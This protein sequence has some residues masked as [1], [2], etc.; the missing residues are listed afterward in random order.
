MTRY[1]E[2]VVTTDAGLRNR[3]APRAQHPQLSLA[4]IFLLLARLRL[5]RLQRRGL[6]WRPASRATSRGEMP[7]ASKGAGVLL[8][9]L[10]L[11]FSFGVQ[12]LTSLMA[13]VRA[14]GSTSLLRHAPLLASL[15][16]AC[17]LTLAIG[18][19]RTN[20]RHEGDEAAWLATL[21]APAW[22]LQAAKLGEAAL[23]NLVGWLLLFP[24]FNSLAIL[25]GLG[26]LA[27]FVALAVT[28]P[29]LACSALLGSVVD[30]A[31]IALS[32]AVI[33]R[34]L[35]AAGP[36]LGSL[37]VLFWLG[38]STLRMAKVDVWGWLDRVPELA[39]LPFSEPARA[40]VSAHTARLDAYAWAGLFVVEM[41][42]VLALG[43]LA[44][45]R[46]Y[47]A[48]LVLG[49]DSRRGVRAA[50]PLQ[51]RGARAGVLSG[52][53]G[54]MVRQELL[55]LSR[56]P[57]YGLRLLLCIGLFNGL[58][59]FVARRAPGVSPASLPSFVLFGV[60]VLL[61]VAQAPLLERERA[62]LWQCRGAPPRSAARARGG[63]LD[64]LSEPDPAARELA[65]AQGHPRGPGPPRRA[66][67]R[68]GQGPRG[69][70]ARR[71]A[72]ERAGDRHQPDERVRHRPLHRDDEQPDGIAAGPHGR[73]QGLASGARERGLHRGSDRRGGAVSRHALRR[74]A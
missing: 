18:S 7:G 21:P 43:T 59:W 32:R 23:L 11:L 12:S 64:F 62:A 3:E 26:L 17:L 41:A 58:A 4:R 50:S 29:L 5:V 71:P 34:L 31:P 15:Q 24:F 10:L 57:A 56:N 55:W 30:A 13:L 52:L 39:W 8:W 45:R 42:L 40:I 37:V 69:D 27:P 44:L 35:R 25:S 60:G 70:R 48:D 63:V 72:L 9:F 51:Q 20:D 33:F 36:L 68:L 67:A 54:G 61:L 1:H 6:G 65:V 47:R 19:R 46:T 38:E 66:R 2:A 49:R 74:P 14:H 73:A 28:L 22:V 53:P 16:I